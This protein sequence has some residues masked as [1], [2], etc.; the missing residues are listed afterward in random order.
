MKTKYYKFIIA[1]SI[2][3]NI[4]PLT[5]VLAQTTDT[6][7]N[8]LLDSYYQ[9]SLKLDPLSATFSGDHRYDDQL[10]NDISAPYLKMKYAFD[11]KYLKLLS[12]YNVQT[13]STADKISYGYLKEILTD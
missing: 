11:R 6:S 1:W 3:S 13:L 10:A 7:L 8:K 4:L 2:I 12:N 5:K 9:E